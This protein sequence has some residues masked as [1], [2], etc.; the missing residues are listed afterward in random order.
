M[1]ETE[2][3][4]NEKWTLEKLLTE[5]AISEISGSCDRLKEELRAMNIEY[6]SWKR[7]AERAGVQPT[8]EDRANAIA[9]VNEGGDE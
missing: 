9:Q 5:Q 8:E 4:N 7:C 1:R 2:S 3:Q 6:Q